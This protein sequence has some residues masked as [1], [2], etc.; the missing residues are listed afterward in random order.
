MLCNNLY[1]G[2][3]FFGGIFSNFT[4]SLIKIEIIIQA[5]MYYKL[6]KNIC[7]NLKSWV[8]GNH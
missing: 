8:V 4:G 5:D 1:I 6:Y 2:K 3:T 7:A